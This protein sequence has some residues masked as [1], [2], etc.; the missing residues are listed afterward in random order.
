NGSKMV[1]YFRMPTSGKINPLG[2]FKHLPPLLKNEI[3]QIGISSVVPSENVMYRQT[4][5][6]FFNIKPLFISAKNNLTISVRTDNPAKTGA[7]RIC[8]ASYGFQLYKKKKNIIIAVLDTANTMDIVIV[9]GEFKVII[10]AGFAKSFKNQIRIKAK[11]I[12]NMVLK[13][14]NEILIINAG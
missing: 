2:I 12:D 8:L 4:C 9:N 6:K 3:E 11:F 1:F 14:I 5:I 10:T 7:D 13:G